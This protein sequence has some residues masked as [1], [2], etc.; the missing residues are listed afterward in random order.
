MYRL[1]TKRS[2]KQLEENANVSFFAETDN[3]AGTGHVTFCYSLT[4]WTTELWS[5]ALNGHAWV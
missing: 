1:A 2:E 3:Q 4:S 5:V